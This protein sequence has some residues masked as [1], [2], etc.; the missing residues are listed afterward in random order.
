[1]I[2]V[3]DPKVSLY[4]YEE[5]LG[6]KYVPSIYPLSNV[7]TILRPFF[8][9]SWWEKKKERRKIIVSARHATHSADVIFTPY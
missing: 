2:R 1:M 6:M 3:K 8:F 4:F 9:C 5:I 7:L